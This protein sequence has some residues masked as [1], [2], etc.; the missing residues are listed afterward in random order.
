MPKFHSHLLYVI[1]LVAGNVFSQNPKKTLVTQSTTEKITIDGRFDEKIWATAN[2][3][4][5]FLMVEPDNGKVI[6]PEKKT[7]V[8]LVYDNEAVYIAATLY[9]DEPR[10][11]MKQLTQRDVFGS[12]DHFGVQINGYNDGQ[13]E[14]RFFVSAADV[15]IDVFYTESNGE[16]FSWNAIWDSKAR[17]T[18]F[19]WV[20]EMKIP[21]AA[22]RF[23][24]A[25]KQT[26]GLNFYR[27]I[28]RKNG[29]YTWN[30]LDNKINSESNQAGI[31]EG[32]EN[33]NTPTRLFLIPYSSFYLNANDSQ[34]TI[35]EF[36]GGMDIKYGIND[37]F[38]L[39]AI[40]IP[41]FGQTK[42]D[43]VQLN[44]GAFEQ[45]FDENRAFFTE[46]TDLFNK[47]N[48]L[49][50]RRIGQAPSVQTAENE[51]AVEVPG[52]TKLINAVKI[53][54][55]TR[56][57]LGIGFLNAISEK[58]S[59]EIKNT[60]TNETSLRTV[61]P[62]TNYNVMVLDQRFNKNS[63]V[64]LVN[65]NVTR[66]GSFRDANVSALVWDLNTRS[67]SF[68]ALGNF[69]YSNVNDTKDKEGIR[70][71][72]EFNKTKGKIRFGA[73]GF[74]VTQDFDSNDLG[75]NFE[76]GY[77]NLYGNVS[78]RILNPTKTLNMFQIFFNNFNQF[79]KETGLV[80]AN[81]YNV[82]FNARTKQNH[83]FGAGINIDPLETHEFDPRL[84]INN[85]SINPSRYGGWFY[86][87][88][89]YNYK[90]A[91]DLEPSYT[92]HN[93]KGREL[94]D[95]T[96]SPRYRFSDKLLLVYSFYGFKYTNDNGYVT[97]ID[98]DMNPATSED[99]I[100]GYR[101]VVSY[102]NTISARYALNSNMSFTLLA[103]HYWSYSENK[104]YLLL[105]PNGRLVDYNNPVINQNQDFS[106]WNLDLTYSWWFAPG[107]QISVLYRNQSNRFD[108]IITKD[109]DYNVKSL[110]NDSAL[111]HTFSVSI[112]YYIDYNSLKNFK[113]SKTFT[114]PKERMRF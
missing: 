43:N 98:T 10:K 66:N 101:N 11:I 7:E 5:D 59:V 38:T 58:T 94:Y 83:D 27:E 109:F 48:L 24:T 100:F 52:S 105:Q 32:I 18:E 25:S 93:E 44:L 35:G 12:A 70:S 86:F 76:T 69:E 63:S 55:R 39:D 72:A 1:L 91:F 29:K 107:S 26:W 57:G 97:R 42:F 46:G 114:K 30:L 60:D 79:Q 45:Q 6:A 85:Y 106:T 13:Q 89:N 53:S 14:F 112:K 28:K 102:S 90:F 33:I 61:A 68:Q 54:G 40:L 71:F 47:G 82:N 34:K 108:G 4:T 74:I 8:K 2:V 77:Y 111:N 15:Q 73:G 3:A 103:R 36:K 96:F 19:G 49:Y 23:S 22:L 95:I 50:T 56:G 92:K 16:D 67:N 37:A 20:V 64:S 31:L 113:G 84:G 87:S 88:S 81:N 80:I 110:L 99:V 62:L 21:Y 75:I 9:D 78:Y 65:T 104:K 17:I 41:D 51:T